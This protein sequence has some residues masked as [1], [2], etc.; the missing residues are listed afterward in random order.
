[1][2]HHVEALLELRNILSVLLVCLTLPHTAELC[3]TVP[4]DLG[5]EE[6]ETTTTWLAT[7]QR[8]NRQ[9]VEGGMSRH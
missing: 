6:R 2:L 4:L 5:K 9:F 8:P 3:L 7:E 1:M